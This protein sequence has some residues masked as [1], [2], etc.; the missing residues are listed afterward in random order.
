ML[1][2]PSERAPFKR[3]CYINRQRPAYYSI[4]RIWLRMPGCTGDGRSS[5]A[6]WPQSFRIPES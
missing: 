1:L 6:A 5:S 4:T 2:A 3:D